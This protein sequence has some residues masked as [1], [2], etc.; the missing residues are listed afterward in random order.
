[1]IVS[2]AIA[3]LPVWRSPMISSRWPRPI[4]IIES[5]AFSPV[6]TGWFTGWRSTTPGACPSS[7]RVSV[8]AI[9]PLPSIGMPIAFT[10]R[11]I[12]ASPT[13][14]D[15]SFPVRRTVSPCLIAS[16][17]PKSAT[18]TLSSSRFRTMPFTSPGNSTISPDMASSRPQTRAM[19]SPTCSTVPT[20]S[21]SS[22][23]SY[24]SIS[25]SS[26]ALTSSGLNAMYEPLAVNPGGEEPAA[27][28]PEL[29]REGPVDDM[30]IQRDDRSPD[31]GGVHLAREHDGASGA[32]GQRARQR[33]GL[34]L[35][36]RDGRPHLEPAQ[37]LRLL[38]QLLELVRD[39]DPVIQPAA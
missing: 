37:S 13:G 5:S 6:C 25:C 39:H 28:P 33:S 35:G 16:S 8:V 23:D 26:T 12:I 1:M 19:P 2:I 22:R 36:E 4:G 30:M 32:G 11:P 27:D 38:G 21:I 29:G 10:T 15:A 7:D 14:I 20:L 31:E 24:R 18:P 17:E 34:G 3:V 9:G